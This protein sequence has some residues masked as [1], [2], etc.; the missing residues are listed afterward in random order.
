MTLSNLSLAVTG[1]PTDTL[2]NIGYAVLTD[3][4][5][6]QSV[7]RTLN[8]SG[9]SGS[10][11]LATS[12]GDTLD[13]GS[14]TTEFDVNVSAVTSAHKVTLV[15]G[16]GTSSVVITGA[17]EIDSSSLG[18]WF[19]GSLTGIGVTFDGSDR[20]VIDSDLY[21]PGEDITIKGDTVTI[22]GHTIDTGRSAPGGALVTTAGD[23]TIEGHSITIDNGA[24]ILAQGSSTNGDIT[25]TAL[26]DRAKF[27]TGFANINNVSATVTIGDTGSSSNYTVIKGGNITIDANAYSQH[28][29]QL[30][31]Y[32]ST[33]ITGTIKHAAG[34]V[35][36]GIVGFL[37]SLSVVAAVTVATSTATV[38]IGQYAQIS[39]EHFHC[40]Q[41]GQ[42]HSGR[43]AHRIRR[44]R[45]LRPGQYDLARDGQRQHHYHGERHHRGDHR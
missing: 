30:S 43:L 36:D 45:G 35:A 39:G 10:V 3:S 16:T 18:T 44:G 1:G 29:F 6:S 2:T 24:Q 7:S 28:F 11:T 31:D 20:A 37:D 25:I 27:T 17:H 13:G 12:R 23:I 19:N 5:T 41:H 42:G 40:P 9:F 21:L 38:D 32:A 15:P 8:A 22:S 34:K 14:G 33:D 4:G 26:D